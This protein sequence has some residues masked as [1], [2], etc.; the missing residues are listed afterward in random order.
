[1]S[2]IEPT[3]A[4][5]SGG[6]IFRNGSHPPDS[7]EHCALEY[8][9]RRLLNRPT[10]GDEHK[11]PLIRAMVINLNDRSESDEVR[12]SVLP[13][14]LDLSADLQADA[15]ALRELPAIVDD[16]S[17]NACSTV[18]FAA[19]DHASAVYSAVYSAVDSAVRSAVYSAVRSAVYSAVYSAV[20]SAVYSAVR[21]TI[22][23]QREVSIEV[24]D[25][26]LA[27]RPAGEP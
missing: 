14:W 23:K 13:L 12:T 4:A 8:V 6:V 26:C 7:D 15:A 19:R 10:A 3:T 20:D 16:D 21:P 18:L 17:A 5:A 22:E 2:T 27:M 25:E 1:M 9:N 11:C 24:L